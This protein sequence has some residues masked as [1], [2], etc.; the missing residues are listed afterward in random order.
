[1]PFFIPIESSNSVSTG[2]SLRA[3]SLDQVDDLYPIDSA[4]NVKEATAHESSDTTGSDDDDNL[5]VAFSI[6]TE[7]YP[8]RYTRLNDKFSLRSSTEAKGGLDLAQDEQNS[9]T[10]DDEDD[11]EDGYDDDFDDN[12]DWIQS[13]HDYNDDDDD[14]VVTMVT[15]TPVVSATSGVLDRIFSIP[16]SAKIHGNKGVTIKFHKV[17]MDTQASKGFH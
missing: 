5:D 11:Y 9:M 12:D 15:S 17:T 8:Q 4:H 16:P 14:F 1:M 6:T 10:E 7:T 13:E 3:T 2:G